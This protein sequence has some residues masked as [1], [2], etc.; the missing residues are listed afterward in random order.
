MAFSR[1]AA[2]FFVFALIGS[3]ALVG[4]GAVALVGPRVAYGTSVAHED[5]KISEIGPGK[6]FVLL[7][8][9]GQQL[10]F[11]CGSQCRAS[12]AHIQRHLRE[13]AHTDVY[14]IHGPDG[15]LVALDV[16]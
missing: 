15:S 2:I 5:G 7:T 11:Q 10:H 14:Y 4:V 9:S 8:A 1:I 3:L 13:H 16:D 6:D 12:L